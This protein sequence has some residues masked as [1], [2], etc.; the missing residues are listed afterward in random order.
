MSSIK[1]F[2]FSPQVHTQGAGSF[3]LQLRRRKRHTFSG[4]FLNED[5]ELTRSHSRKLISVVRACAR[6]SVVRACARVSVV[7]ACARACA[8]LPCWLRS[9]VAGVA[10]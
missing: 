8:L 3:W 1:C 9:M 4:L 10:Y 6:V 2:D 5:H 7:R